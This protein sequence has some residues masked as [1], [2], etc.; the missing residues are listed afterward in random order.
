M[1]R[2]LDVVVFG[3]TGFAGRLVAEYLADKYADGSLKWAM[4]GRSARKLAEVRDEIARV[5]PAAAGIELIVADSQDRPA[6]DAMAGRAKVVCTTVGPYAKYGSEL[7]AACIAQGAD[8]VDLTG[9]VQW[10][11]RMIDAHHEEAAAA[12]VR[13][14]HC[15]GFDSIPSDLGVWALQDYARRE[16]GGPCDEVRYYLWWAKGGFSG[17]T[18]ASLINVLKEAE[19]DRSVRRVMGDPYS[20]Y[21]KGAARGEDGQ[22]QRGPRKAS[23]GWTAPFMMAAV[24][25]RVVRRS[26]ALLGFEYGA[27]FR[28]GESMRTGEGVKGAVG[29]VALSAGMGLGMAALM[30]KPL[31]ALLEERVLPAPGEGPSREKIEAGG[32]EAR[33]VGLRGGRE[34]ARCKVRGKR[35]PGYGATALML[36][37]SAICLVRD[38]PQEGAPLAGVL[39][40]ASAMGGPLVARL[41][42]AGMVVDAG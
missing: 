25:E 24:N 21:P 30:V 22:E 29:A 34:V 2:D 28:Y 23:I 16:L 13:I 40:P 27:G 19:Q 31:R 41:R 12:G 20:L 38:V 4:A 1:A 42:A 36:A 5:Y 11:R 7:V 37:E 15:C 32:F 35:D 10:V 3:A 17:G 18:V 26:N 33:L 6:L 8:Y 9:E 14:V 39:T